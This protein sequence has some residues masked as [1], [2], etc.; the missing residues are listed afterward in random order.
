LDGLM[1]QEHLC[2][3]CLMVIV[4][5]TQR[6][7]AEAR[8]R[9]Q[10]G[11]VGDQQFGHLDMSAYS[12]PV[13]GR[14]AILVLWIDL[15]SF[16]EQSGSSIHLPLQRSPVERGISGIRSRIDVRAVCDQEFGNLTLIIIRRGV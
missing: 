14:V 16:C 12:S 9:I 15:G 6:S 11:T 8:L 2:G 5:A 4:C 1:P 13:Q 7:A 3:G 10:I